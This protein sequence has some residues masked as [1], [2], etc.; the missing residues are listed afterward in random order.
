MKVTLLL[1]VLGFVWGSMSGVALAADRPETEAVNAAVKQLAGTWRAVATEVGGKQM[2]QKELADYRLVFSG[3]ECSIV[4]G[5]RVISCAVVIDP[6]KTPKCI[7][8]TSD[9]VT[10]PGIYELKD[11]RLTV[12]LDT[13]GRKRPTE[14][15]TEAGTQQVIRTYERI[16]VLTM[17]H[18]GGWG[19]GIL[20]HFTLE[21]DGTFH[22]QSKK[23][24][25]TGN[26]PSNETKQL[27]EDV[28]SA[29]AGPPAEDAGYVEFKWVDDNGKR[30]SQ[31]YSYPQKAPCQQ[32]LKKIEGLVGKYRN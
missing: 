29:G 23:G 5:K 31:D 18:T 28:S 10:W 24:K 26:I 12:F 7:D 15:N 3:A 25:V 11:G 13:T 8:L 21:K 9:K 22:W 6:G 2:D 14:F 30:S 20:A 17:K 27:I 4:S 1:V 19:A 32:L 16:E